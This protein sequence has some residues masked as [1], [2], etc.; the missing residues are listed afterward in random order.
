ML[1]P[2][3]CGCSMLLFAPAVLGGRPVP[4]RQ[5]A[6]GRQCRRPRA[7]AP[8]CCW[9]F[10][11]PIAGRRSQCSGPEP[12][13]AGSVCLTCIAS[14]AVCQCRRAHAACIQLKVGHQWRCCCACCAIR[15]C[16]LW[17]SF[18]SRVRSPAA[19]SVQTLAS[20]VLSAA[21]DCLR[22]GNTALLYCYPVM[23][24]SL[25][26]PGLAADHSQ[27]PYNAL[28]HETARSRDW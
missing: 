18:T 16:W 20:G 13:R 14:L 21:V 7:V 6:G 11:E 22:S 25:A 3:Q 19:R 12:C 2:L 28:Q 10:L 4:P 1:L 27:Q 26:S 5:A 9:L 24:H 23:R 8:E 15:A 17:A